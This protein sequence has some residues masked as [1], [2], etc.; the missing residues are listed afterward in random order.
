[1][2]NHAII[3]T[4]ESMKGNTYYYPAKKKEY[5]IKAFD[6]KESSRIVKIYTDQ[7]DLT[8]F[9]DDFE[10]DYK[11]LEFITPV[12]TEEEMGQALEV[13]K[14][15]NMAVAH[16]KNVNDGIQQNTL[17]GSNGN[18]IANILMDNIR[19]IQEN[20][21]Y[22]PQAQAMSDVAK[23]YIDLAKTEIEMYKVSAALSR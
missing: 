19:K 3:R 14:S 5:K 7:E 12:K 9:K 22:I 10:E 8:I 18:E 1:M 20:S 16:K 21:S 2:E 11:S 4:L 13:Q 15:A 23:T 17:I 6:C